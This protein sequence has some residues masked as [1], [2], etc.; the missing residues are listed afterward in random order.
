[1]LNQC[2]FIGHLGADPEIRNTQGGDKVANVRLGV[3]EKWNGETRTEWVRCVAF[4]GLADVLE[5]FTSKGSKIRITGKM[6]TRKWQDQSGKDQYTTE[7]IVRELDLLDSKPTEQQ[8][9][10]QHGFGVQGGY[11]D[12]HYDDALANDIPF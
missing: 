8:A 10:Q 1:M 3:S 11:D 2:N 9:A 5:R 6:Q 12:H 4:K 7:I